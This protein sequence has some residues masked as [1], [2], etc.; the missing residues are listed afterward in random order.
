MQPDVISSPKGRGRPKTRHPPPRVFST[1]FSWDYLAKLSKD[2]ADGL[3]IQ[4]SPFTT[5]LA[6]IAL[7]YGPLRDLQKKGKIKKG[8]TRRSRIHIQILLRDVAVTYAKYSNEDA[9]IELRKI[10]GYREERLKDANRNKVD[11]RPPV[12][13]LARV[14]MALWG[15]EF[16]ESLQRHARAALKLI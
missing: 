2:I 1:I 13:I 14:V 4:D 10:N 16:G 12:E 15:D 8:C 6:H 5:E 11:I 9:Q 7:A 3:D